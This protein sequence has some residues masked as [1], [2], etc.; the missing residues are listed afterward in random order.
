MDSEIDAPKSALP[1][2]S[3]A[4][5]NLGKSLGALASAAK[6]GTALTGPGPESPKK[7]DKPEETDT[8]ERDQAGPA[9]G[10][11]ATAVQTKVDR[12][13]AAKPRAARFKLPP[14]VGGTV[15]PVVSMRKL[16]A[17][18]AAKAGPA[19]GSSRAHD[20][21]GRTF[22]RLTVLPAIVLTAWLLTG[23]PLLLA[24]KFLP[25][26]M[27]LISAPL[28]TALGVNVLQRVPSRWPAELPGKV[29]DRGWMPW[30][31]LIGTVLVAA[32]FAAW[33]LWRNSPSLIASRSPGAYFQTGYWIAQHG[34]LPI[35][36]SLAAFGG[37]H[38]G[39]HLS[40]IGFFASGNS[41]VPAVSAG[42]PML[43]AGGFWTSGVT[44]GTVIAP[45]LGGLAVL[46]FGGLV[47]R[48]AGRQ[49]APAGAIV[50]AVTTPELYTSRDAFA[51]TAVQVLLFGGLCLLVDALMSSRA[52][53]RA[54]EPVAKTVPAV[55]QRRGD[56]GGPAHYTPRPPPGPAP[57]P[58]DDSVSKTLRMAEAVFSG[59]SQGESGSETSS[60]S[61]NSPKAAADG[62]SPIDGDVISFGPTNPAGATGRFRAAGAASKADQ[63]QASPDDDIT[64]PIAALPGPPTK[65]KR[66]PAAFGG[67]L[68]PGI[69]ARLKTSGKRLVAW[70]RTLT[71]RKVA[72]GITTGLTPE[73]M[74]AFLGG[75]AL[76]LTSLLSIGSLVYV[77]PVIVVAGILL[78]A[79][80]AVGVA[81]C[82]G[83]FIGCAYGFSASYLL[84]RPFSDSLAPVL[85]VL[86]YDAA[87]AAGVTI[88]IFLL[89]SRP[90]IGRFTR[91]ILAKRP[92]RWLPGLASFLVL[93]ALADFAAR[94][95]VQIVRGVLGHAE[96][97]FVAALQRLAHLR[98]DP[99]RL[100][101]EDTL[102][103]VIWY[104]GIA[105][106]L[107]AA[108]GAAVL[109]RRCLRSL[110]TWNDE[111]GAG[112][113]WALPIAVIFAGSAA[114]LW[115]PF[116]VPDQPWASRRL[117]PIVI[118][119][120]VLLATWTA[121]WLTRRAR[122]RGAGSV[123]A[124]FVGAFCVGAMLLPAVT[125]SFGFG[126]TH[127]GVGGGLHPSAGGLAQHR[128]G[129]GQTQAV[130]GL[131]SAIGRSSSVVI[132]DQHLAENFTQ[133]IRGMCG[134]PVAWVGKGNQTATVDAVMAGI[135][136]AGRHA[137]VLGAREAEVSGFGGSPTKVM[138]LFTTQ[139]S[140]ELTQ[141]AGAPWP[142]RYEIWMAEG[143]PTTQGA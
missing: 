21:A 124:G 113:N 66:K 118:P 17:K 14:W 33:Q 31:G 108:F 135:A 62:T 69:A 42:L 37:A 27:L 89:V 11:A 85:R 96:A 58:A 92:L 75:V 51:E 52:A 142:A 91:K 30:F 7:N 107:L 115:Q 61:G 26:P 99:T 43:L 49:W 116:T 10:P 59:G 46:S 57:R 86:G 132:V 72:T 122:E 129:A 2:S 55:T 47:G 104:A 139:E 54:A 133:V 101:S 83:I 50:L 24:G 20:L 109:I 73:R 23:L 126:L 79:R 77:L 82:L 13:P 97:D 125:T 71:W 29:R 4:T 60:A 34:S 120:M 45:V 140:H 112:M 102:Y 81:F 80:R 74:L 100:Y 39:L 8:E 15:W 134:V 119:G 143:A 40:S 105:T 110:F 84:A 19:T 138:D 28:A 16:R 136:K 53:A 128:V 130:R 1:A 123:T 114:V 117:V 9:E 94:P 106:V 95:Y 137:V 127:S 87:G 78:A 63:D 64:A 12:K 41:V 36:G 111:S 93:V 103:W 48:L 68:A 32:G 90:K 38:A 6:A 98:V 141:A 88:L 5:S 25:V 65:P 3:T 76:G 44:G 22:G 35:S 18:R 70:A 67:R 121:A 131:C 56:P